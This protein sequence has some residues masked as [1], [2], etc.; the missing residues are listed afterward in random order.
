MPT[1]TKAILNLAAIAILVGAAA[2]VYHAINV[3][4]QVHIDRRKSELQFFNRLIHDNWDGIHSI[5][6][7]KKT[8]LLAN[9]NPAY[10]GSDIDEFR[11][12]QLMFALLFFGVT[13]VDRL[14]ALYKLWRASHNQ[15][16]SP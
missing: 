3:L 11:V 15:S 13:I 5:A 10:A 16:V 1:K 4:A 9:L 2:F 14:V 6:D 12:L 7:E 8:I